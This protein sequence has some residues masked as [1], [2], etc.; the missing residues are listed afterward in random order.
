VSLPLQGIDVL[1]MI[2]LRVGR[3]MQ[4]IPHPIPYQ[5]SKRNLAKLIGN[6]VPRDIETWFEPFVGSAAMSLWM[7]AHYPPKRVIFGDSLIEI[8]QLWQ[9]ILTHP[10]VVASRYRRVW[11]GQIDGDTDYFNSIRR[12]FNEARDPVD[13]LYLMCRCVKNAVRFN[14]KGLFTQ[15]VDK[16]RLGMHPDKMEKAV[17][18][19]SYLLR[20]RTE[21]RSGDWLDTTADAKPTDFIYMDPPYLGTSTGNDRRYAEWMTQDRL[22]G[23]LETLNERNLRFLLSYDGMSGEKTYGPPLPK[24]LG[25]TQLL[26]NAGRSSQ[27]TLNGS[28]DQTFE[29]LYLSQ[30]LFA[31]SDGLAARQ[32]ETLLEIELAF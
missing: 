32:H 8:T 26:L 18:G 25:M 4:K 14:A 5:G 2:V 28:K 29:S 13:L 9:S 22:I 6:Y 24:H 10:E 15:S 19:A 1:A 17:N 11:V 23:G 21:I 20:G 7:L 27:A 16:R 30:G 31:L 12:R 3:M